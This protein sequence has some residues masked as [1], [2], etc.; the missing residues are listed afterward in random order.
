MKISLLVGVGIGYVLGARAGHERYE[1][2]A[3]LGRKVRGSQT[4]QSTA[5]VLNAQ[6]DEL[7]GKFVSLV[8]DRHHDDTRTTTARPSATAPNGYRS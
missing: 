2:L 4:V 8:W 1:Q 6:V 7:R 5:G 3:Q